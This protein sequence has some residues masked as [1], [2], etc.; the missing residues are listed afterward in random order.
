[1]ATRVNGVVGAVMR[2]LSARGV[3]AVVAV[4]AALV[5]PAVLAVRAEAAPAGACLDQQSPGALAIVR[6]TE[7]YMLPRYAAVY[8]SAR[9]QRVVGDWALVIVT[10]R[11]AADRVAVVLHRTPAGLW[12]VVGGPGTAFAPDGRPAG[13][14]DELFLSDPAAPCG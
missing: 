9:V 6:A 11:I 4:S 10:P 2:W 3:A 7:S 13:L 8:G 1:M 14:P 5:A 12:T